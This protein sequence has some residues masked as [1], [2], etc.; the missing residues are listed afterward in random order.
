MP[1]AFSPPDCAS[2]KSLASRPN[3]LTANDRRFNAR[4]RTAVTHADRRRRRRRRLAAD[5]LHSSHRPLAPPLKTAESAGTATPLSPMA[6]RHLRNLIAYRSS[7]HAASRS[8]GQRRKY[9]PSEHAGSL[10]PD[11]ETTTTRGVSSGNV[12]ANSLGDPSLVASR[13]TEDT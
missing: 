4:R 8:E 6:A 5:A 3:E 9:S 1:T 10:P 12:L 2:L 7:A 13:S 11:V